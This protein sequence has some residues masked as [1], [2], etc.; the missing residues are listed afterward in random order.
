MEQLPA[1]VGEAN[2]NGNGGQQLEKLSFWELF[3]VSGTLTKAKEIAGELSS[4]IEECNLA[5]RIGQGTHLRVEAWLTLGAMLGLTAHTKETRRILGPDGK[6]EG[7]EATVQVCRASDGAA[8]SQADGACFVSEKLKRRG[9]QSYDRWS[10]NGEV[11]QHAVM[12]MAQTRATSR[13]LAQVLRWIP[14][15]SGYSGTPAEDMTVTSAP[16]SE[17]RPVVDSVATPSADEIAPGVIRSVVIRHKTSTTKNNSERWAACV[18]FPAGVDKW[19]STFDASHGEMI[20]KVSGTG[21]E[22]EIR[23]QQDGKYAN[24]LGIELS[25]TEPP[26]QE[27]ERVVNVSKQTVAQAFR[28]LGIPAKDQKNIVG[29]FCQWQDVKAFDDLIQKDRQVLH[30]L[31]ESR[32]IERIMANDKISSDAAKAILADWI[33]ARPEDDYADVP[34]EDRV[35]LAQAISQ[36]AYDNNL[37][38]Y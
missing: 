10:E 3:G 32:V 30:A 24:L 25:S 13:S 7:Y 34:L 21:E 35:V 33:E 18:K 37:V 17:S 38:E 4:V 12:S 29:T 2:G 19:L 27:K 22:V 14:V 28:V 16:A 36:G 6:L 15:M 1:K 5:V 11:N 23:W 26:A 9:G 8:V 20:E 31:I